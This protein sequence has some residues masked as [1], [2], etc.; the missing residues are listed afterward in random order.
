MIL[1]IKCV[2]RYSD[3]MWWLINS[4]NHG[5]LKSTNL[6]VLER[7]VL[8]T[9]RWRAGWLRTLLLCWTWRL[10]EKLLI[11]KKRKNNI[12][13]GCWD[14]WRIPGSHGK[15]GRRSV[16]QLT[17]RETEQKSRFLKIVGMSAFSQL[18]MMILE[19]SCIIHFWSSLEISR[20]SLLMVKWSW[21][22][23]IMPMTQQ[24]K[25]MLRSS[26]ASKQKN[27]P[28]QLHRSDQAASS[29]A[30]L[31]WNSELLIKQPRR[32]YWRTRNW[33]SRNWKREYKKLRW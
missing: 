25:A 14:R 8:L 17:N 3:L 28:K 18:P 11:W 7:T 26:K 1:K 27:A 22:Q 20:T 23:N 32:T 9:F 29:A 4:W 16:Q 19:C 2:S 12:L 15:R 10:N 21:R 31:K 6:R 30:L 5:L 13:Y 24:W 33:R